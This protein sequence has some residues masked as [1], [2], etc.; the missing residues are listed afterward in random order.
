MRERKQKRE[1]LNIQSL[2]RL[3]HRRGTEDMQNFGLLKSALRLCVF[4]RLIALH[5]PFLKIYHTTIL[6]KKQRNP[7]PFPAGIRFEFFK[8]GRA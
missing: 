2:W 7:N 3:P 1:K 5:F 6:E 4:Y 8:D